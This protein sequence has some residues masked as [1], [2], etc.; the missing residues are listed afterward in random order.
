MPLLHQPCM[1]YTYHT[2]GC[3][4]AQGFVVSLSQRK[5]LELIV[6]PL[7]APCLGMHMTCGLS[8]QP[9]RMLQQSRSPHRDVTAKKLELDVFLFLARNRCS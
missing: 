3:D 4:V 6:G 2:A 8:A 5:K 7:R 1:R 9:L